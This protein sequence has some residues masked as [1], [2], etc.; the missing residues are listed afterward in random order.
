VLDAD[1]PTRLLA[2]GQELV[3]QPDHGTA[4]LQGLLA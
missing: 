2:A 3:G 4:Y 1:P